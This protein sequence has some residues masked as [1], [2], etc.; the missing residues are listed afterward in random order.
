MEMEK[1][2]QLINKYFV[3]SFHYKLSFMNPSESSQIE[4]S[5]SSQRSHLSWRWN[6]SGAITARL[7]KLHIPATPP[8]FAKVS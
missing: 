4:T 3:N 5:S 8:F 6:Q 2:S 1:M 7:N